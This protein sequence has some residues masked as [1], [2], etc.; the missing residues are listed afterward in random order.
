MDLIL[1]L[2]IYL[3]AMIGGMIEFLLYAGHSI[4]ITPSTQ[5]NLMRWVWSFPSYNKETEAKRRNLPTSHQQGGWLSQVLSPGLFGPRL[6]WWLN[7]KESACNI[8]A[9]GDTGSIPG[10]RRSPEGGH[11]NPLQYLPG[12]SHGRRNLAGPGDRKEL[13]TTEATKQ[14]HMLFGPKA[15]SRPLCCT[16]YISSHT[17][18]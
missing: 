11:G 15:H 7:S 9:S 8:G 10:L 13:Y 17:D 18:L 1:D 5:S 12:E 16:A 3:L 14:A 4:F 2:A 6:P